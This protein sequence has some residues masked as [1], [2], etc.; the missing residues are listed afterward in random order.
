MVAL[1][2]SRH[3]L[4]EPNYCRR[5]TIAKLTKLE[6]RVHSYTMY[7]VKTNYAGYA[8]MKSL[9]KPWYEIEKAWS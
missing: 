8:A 1:E 6:L 5:F 3:T 9:D 2:T 4:N 7:W